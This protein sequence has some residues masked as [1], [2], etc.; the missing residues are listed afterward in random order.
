MLW[1]ITYLVPLL[2]KK[3]KLAEIG[4]Y[5]FEYN[6]E[7]SHELHTKIEILTKV[8]F[9]LSIQLRVRP[10]R[11]IAIIDHVSDQLVIVLDRTK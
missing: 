8:I 5:L 3:L 9:D 6:Y 7:L 4:V 2:S 1:S 11:V 10:K